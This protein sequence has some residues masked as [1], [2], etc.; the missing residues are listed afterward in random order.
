M[1][2]KDHLIPEPEH[3]KISL[4][5]ATRYDVSIHKVDNNPYYLPFGDKPTHWELTI[6]P[7]GAWIEEGEEPEWESIGEP[8]EFKMSRYSLAPTI[9][10]FSE[11]I[12]N[13]CW[14]TIKAM[15]WNVEEDF[16]YLSDA[17]KFFVEWS[18][19]EPKHIYAFLKEIHK[20]YTKT[21]DFLRDIDHYHNRM[22]N[23]LKFI[24]GM[25]AGQRGMFL[26]S[27]ELPI[28]R[29]FFDFL[30]IEIYKDNLEEVKPL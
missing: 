18:E 24:H 10:Q 1:N 3:C 21:E 19:I 4:D 11:H 30:G 14:S 2:I 27:F 16:K 12:Y 15:G 23:N 25:I 26:K 13:E 9:E 8:Y 17:N 20:D 28:G 6:Q 5:S 29:H 7:M 22:Y